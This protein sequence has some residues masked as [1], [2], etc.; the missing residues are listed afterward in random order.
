MKQFRTL[1]K[2]TKPPAI[3]LVSL[4]LV[5]SIGVGGV[6]APAAMLEGIERRRRFIVPPC[7]RLDGDGEDTG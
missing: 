1:E 4:V 7:W 2:E 3:L 6:P 5:V